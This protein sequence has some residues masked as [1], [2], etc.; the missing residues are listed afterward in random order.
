MTKPPSWDLSH[1]EFAW[2]WKTETGLDAYDYPDPI[3][4]RESPQNWDEYSLIASSFSRKHGSGIEPALRS[5]L[6]TLATSTVRLCCYGT[7][8]GTGHVLRSHAGLTDRMGAV[9]FQRPT[10]QNDRTIRLTACRPD[11]T[12]TYFAATLPPAEPGGAG[13][14]HGYTP[15]VRGNEP[16]TTWLRSNDGRLPEDERIRKLLRL[17]R[18]AEGQLIIESGVRARQQLPSTY[19]SWADISSGFAAGRYLIEV[20]ESDTVVTTV[21]P[22]LLVGK[23]EQKVRLLTNA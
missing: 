12:L 21:S 13:D 16:V 20:T 1:D 23:L 19:L 11:D 5:A 22:T 4:I 15:R 6:R 3:Q 2:L 10:T 9:L 8:T 18:S 17:R 14:M 7:L